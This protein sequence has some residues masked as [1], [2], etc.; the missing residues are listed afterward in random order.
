MS[1][2]IRIHDGKL[3]LNP[4]GVYDMVNGNWLEFNVAKLHLLV[5]N[6][7]K[8]IDIQCDCGEVQEKLT[9]YGNELLAIAEKLYDN[10]YRDL[11]E[12][13]TPQ[14][15]EFPDSEKWPNT[16]P[17]WLKE[18]PWVD[19]SWHNDAC[20]SY[21]HP[22][23]KLIVW[24]HPDIEEHREDCSK[25]FYVNSVEVDEDGWQEYACEM[26]ECD[27]EEELKHWLET[28]TI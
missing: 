9:P 13:Y 19:Q 20:P 18:E 14:K 1:Q 8:M 11:V 24:V 12:N 10:Y 17:T 25:K 22:A 16:I 3:E 28:A 15:V 26:F 6:I 27:T 4:G 21:F 2:E 23:C 7:E 5:A